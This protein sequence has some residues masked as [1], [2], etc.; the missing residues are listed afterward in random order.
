MRTMAQLRFVPGLV[1][2]VRGEVV[3]PMLLLMLDKE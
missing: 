2:G 1:G 3:Q